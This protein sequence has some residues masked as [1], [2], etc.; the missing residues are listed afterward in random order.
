MGFTEPWDNT[1]PPDTQAIKLGAQDIRSTKVDVQERLAAFAVGLLASRP[2]PEAGFGS[3]G[4]G[5]Q[6]FASDTG[7]LFQWNG[8][9]WVLISVNKNFIDPTVQTQTNQAVGTVLNA[10]TIPANLIQRSSSVEVSGVLSTTSSQISVNFGAA[11]IVA[12]VLGTNVATFKVVI[13]ID[14]SGVQNCF[15]IGLG[16]INSFGLVQNL[17]QD[18]TMP[19]AVTSKVNHS[20]GTCTSGGLLVKVRF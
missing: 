15:Q 12:N 8:V 18:V 4:F 16:S 2:T 11:G 19:I 17:N 7:Q 6:Y 1:F 9:A 14:S 3:S 20:T 13:L 5:V 10:V